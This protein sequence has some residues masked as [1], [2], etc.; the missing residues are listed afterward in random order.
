MADFVQHKPTKAEREERRAQREAERLAAFAEKAKN[1]PDSVHGVPVV[2]IDYTAVSKKRV[3]EL[4]R[5]FGECRKRF[6]ITLARNHAADL[7]AAGLSDS[8]IDLMAKGRSPGGYN[9]HH[10]TPLAGGG[11]NEFSNFILIKDEPYHKDFHKVSD[12]Q[13]V[14][15]KEGETKKVKIPMPD[16]CVFIPPERRAE[17]VKTLPPALMAR[18]LN[19]R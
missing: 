19:S 13:I 6:L 15:M 10:K 16:G 7:K 4:R 11:K 2:E 18:R 14:G 1:L 8:A 17:R 5:T 12:V 9:V 3:K